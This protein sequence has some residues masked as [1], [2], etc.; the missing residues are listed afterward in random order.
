MKEHNR[1]VRS[2]QQ[3]DIL[4][5]LLNENENASFIR[6]HLLSV[7]IDI[8]RQLTNLLHSSKIQE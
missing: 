4:L 2:L 6:H 7:R 1:L 3:I 8:S 5:D